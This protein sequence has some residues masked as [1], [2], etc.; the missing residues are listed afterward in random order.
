MVRPISTYRA[1]IPFTTPAPTNAISLHQHFSP[2]SSFKRFAEK[3]EHFETHPETYPD[4]GVYKPRD[5]ICDEGSEK[6]PKVEPHRIRGG[7]LSLSVSKGLAMYTSAL[8]VYDAFCRLKN[9]GGDGQVYMH[10][11][12]DAW[13]GQ[14]TYM[15]ALG[16]PYAGISAFLSNGQALA[17]FHAP[18]TSFMD[19]DKS[20]EL[21]DEIAATYYGRKALVVVRNIATVVFSLSVMKK[22][23]LQVPDNVEDLEIQAN[24]NISSLATVL[25]GD[26]T[27]ESVCL[28]ELLINM[29]RLG[30]NK[31]EFLLTLENHVWEELF[32]IAEGKQSAA[33][34]FRALQTRWAGM[35][36]LSELER[37]EIV[38]FKRDEEVLFDQDMSPFDSYLTIPA[39]MMG[40]FPTAA[41][42]Y[43]RMLPAQ[44]ADGNSGG[45]LEL[46]KGGAEDPADDEAQGNAG[47]PGPARQS[48][49]LAAKKDGVPQ[50]PAPEVIKKT[51]RGKSR[52]K[53]HPKSKRYVVEDEEG[54]EEDVEADMIMDWW[55]WEAA[56]PEAR[57]KLEEELVEILEDIDW[58]VQDFA[59]SSSYGLKPPI[60]L[61]EETKKY[62]ESEGQEFEMVDAGGQVHRKK[63]FFHNK[64]DHDAWVTICDAA[65]K[66]NHLFHCM[67][68]DAY[69]A[70]PASEVQAILTKKNIV[71][72]GTPGI[73]VS[74]DLA[75]LETLAERHQR[76]ELQDQSVPV[77]D[78][79]FTVRA[80][81]AIVEDLLECHHLPWERKK[82]MNA[83]S[84]PNPD[85]GI[86]ATPY[87]SDVRAVQRT[88]LDAGCTSSLPISDIRWGLAATEG[89]HSYWH[90]D[91]QG[92]GTSLRVSWGQKG[93]VAAEPKEKNGIAS[94]TFWT[95]PKLDVM[96]ISLEGMTVEGVILNAGDLLLMRSNTLHCAYTLE[97]SI[98][99]GG[100][101]L[102]TA[103]LSRMVCGAVHT[104]FESR[105]ATN[106]EGPVYVS[107]MN[108]LAAFFHKCIALNETVEAD[109]PHLPNIA[110]AD[111]LTNL[112][113]FACGIELLNTLLRDSYRPVSDDAL[114]AA[115]AKKDMDADTALD[116]YDMSAVSHETRLHIACSRGRMQDLLQRIFSRY[117]VLD[118]DGL[119]QDGWHYLWIPTLAWFIHALQDYYSRSSSVNITE[120]GIEEG[121]VEDDEGYIVTHELFS[122]QLDW[123][124]SRWPELKAMV[125]ELPRQNTEFSNLLPPFPAFTLK[126]AD[127]PKEEPEHRTPLQLVKL[128]LRV[129]DSLY[130][131]ARQAFTTPSGKLYV[132]KEG[133]Q[134]GE[135]GDHGPTKRPRRA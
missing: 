120:D 69:R 29:K 81:T 117:A 48:G 104:F 14:S 61:D 38:F 31:P 8:K 97:D 98:C 28:E 19:C 132:R 66:P 83:L 67:T 34:A 54:K 33:G 21:A 113:V 41:F 62:S 123:M 90:I 17:T 11:R 93:W 122:R 108:S 114:V 96:K 71:V 23:Y 49:R 9:T 74:F 127:H 42:P 25:C 51:T 27:K 16:D 6:M 129:G 133:S 101:F 47:V 36:V 110:T 128:G 40:A 116:L 135:S 15:Q 18:I 73:D 94:T 26:L 50:P 13:I 80:R 88:R 107:R 130:L 79:N 115:I 70:L 2:D 59:R 52:R 100:Y 106:T 75:G 24:A 68:Y 111:G 35:D 95:N 46:G 118:G 77:T 92:E 10:E 32:A 76:I 12:R 125:D 7:K 56:P 91:T 103:F 105:V 60:N 1:L 39:E 58:V 37:N 131:A 4:W 44:G 84:F 99:H 119:E 72:T 87:A 3:I 78:D 45:E 134:E 65:Q 22:G 124:I 109:L 112:L 82:S 5:F 89:A 57:V 43:L 102:S 63:W 86:T 53:Q 85:A 20:L 30:N 55:D 126:L 64:E 121:E